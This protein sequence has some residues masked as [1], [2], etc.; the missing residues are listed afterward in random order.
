MKTEPSK[1]P[2]TPIQQD[3]LPSRREFLKSS[4]LAGAGALFASGSASAAILP[5]MPSAG[6]AASVTRPRPAGQ[7]PVYHLTTKPLEKVRVAV[8]GCHR[9]LSHAMASSKFEF[10]ELVAVCDWRTDRAELVA[11]RVAKE[12]GRPRPKVYGG[13]QHVWEQMADRD[14]ID[15]IY[16]ATPWEWHAPMALGV[17]ERGKHALLEVSAAVTVDECWQLVDAS[18]RHQKHCVILENCCYYEDV[19]LL[20]NMIRQGVFGDLLHGECAYIHDLRGML[21]NLDREGEWRR[22]YHYL[23]NGNLYPTHGLGPIA[24]Y[25]NIGCGDQFSHLVSMSTM[26]RGLTQ[27]RDKHQ[28][29]GGIHA[30]ESYICGDMNTTII[31]TVQGRTIM[32][33]HDIVTP[34]PIT[35]LN[36]ISGTGATF[37]GFPSR[38]VIADRERYG[39]SAK[40]S[41]QVELGT[42]SGMRTRRPH[43][44][45]SDEEL[46][47][48]R[49]KFAHPLWTALAEQAKGAGHG[50]ADYLMNYRLLD[51]IRR[52]Q[53]PDSVVYDAA[54]WSCIL[55][56]S[57]IS[58]ASGSMPVG[59]PDFSRGAWTNLRPVPIAG[60]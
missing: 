18:E 19:L 38:L 11:D 9:G 30:G 50:G 28:P 8:I 57:A 59:V 46:A 54:A 4:V 14:H 33:Q 48:I 6:G 41:G 52:G 20:Q 39:L 3:S 32:V 58:V 42:G 10:S 21:F 45:M 34:R 7:R 47:M 44:W 35:K 56:L 17:M 60:I 37:Q 16:I 27:Y 24:Q 43:D 2:G 49:K 22:N 36:L 29:N 1:N 40:V 5:G 15:A 25:M 23:Y 26:E 13:T 55:E 51:R 12:T 31:R 53:T